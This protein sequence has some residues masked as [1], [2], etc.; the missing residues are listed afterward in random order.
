MP[1]DNNRAHI[2]LKVGA[3]TK[4]EWEQHV[5]RREDLSSLSAL[6]RLS[7]S[8]ELSGEYD[9]FE[10][11]YDDILNAFQEIHSEFKWQ[12]EQLKMIK[13]ENVEKP[14][15]EEMFNIVLDRMEELEDGE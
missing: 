5:E 4:Q 6:I 12:N 7:V 1:S 11:K 3:E 14:E 10:S 15:M 8:K 2:H 9:Q 13:N